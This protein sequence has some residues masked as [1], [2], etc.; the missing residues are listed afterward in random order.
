MEMGGITLK[1][2][3]QDLQQELSGLYDEREAGQIVSILFSH[4]AGWNRADVALRGEE[5]VSPELQRSLLSALTDLKKFLPI[6][7]IIGTTTF[8]GIGLNVKPG[9]LIPR[10]ETEE[11]VGLVVGENKQS[12]LQEIPVLD[13]GTGSGCIAIALKKSFPYARVDAVEISGS[14]LAIAAGNATD[15][16]IEVNFIKLDILDDQASESLPGYRIIVSNPP[17]VTDSEKKWM[18]RNVLDFEPHSALFVPD[19]DPLLFYRSI[20]SF[21]FKHLIRPGIL[22]LEINERFGTR[23]KELMLGYGFERVDVLTDFKGKERFVRAEAKHTMSDTS[24]WMV[25]KQLP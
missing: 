15:H 22:Y 3:S 18:S 6:Q 25:D 23:V 17:Y 11:L 21:A 1:K 12:A 10:P 7:Y 24:Y 16:G 20:G 14:A 19:H 2:I 9:V 5:P 13:I 4:F 8:R